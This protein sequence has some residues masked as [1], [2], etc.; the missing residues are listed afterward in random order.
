MVFKISD[1]KPERKYIFA[2]DNNK[3][4]EQRKLI[5]AIS[6]GIGTGLVESQDVPEVFKKA[7]PKLTP[8]QLD[9]DWRKSLMLDLHVT[10]SS[11][12]IAPENPVA[13]ADGE[14][15]AEGGDDAEIIEMDWH[16]KAG[17]AANIQLI[18]NEFAKARGLRPIK[19]F[20]TGPPCSGKTFF[21]KQLGEHYNVP[22]IHMQK[23]L[24]DLLSWDQEK[25]ENWNKRQ[26]DKQRVL[27]KIKAD[28]AAAAER[29]QRE[30]EEAERRKKA[31]M[32]SDEEDAEPKSDDDRSNQDK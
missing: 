12:F 7:H 6:N 14:E 15:P 17:M 25:E 18:K 26:A 21:G 23:L 11:L 28:R 16:C 10:P 13:A 4:Q 5:S 2:V 22:H 27:D 19:I 24:D 20:V 30:K 32:A 29:A 1:K 9:L 3:K 8:I 31:A